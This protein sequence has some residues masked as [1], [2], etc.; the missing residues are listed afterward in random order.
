MFENGFVFIFV[1][2]FLFVIGIGIWAY[3]ANMKRMA[4]LRLWAAERRFRL[5]E[6]KNRGLELRFPEFACLREGSRR[7]GENVLEGT[8]R[9]RSF[10]AFEYHYETYSTDKD[11]KTQ[12]NHHSFAVV[13]VES[14]LRLKPLWIRRENFFDKIGSFIGFDDINF[15]SGEFSRRYHVSAQDRRWAFDVLHQHAIEFLLQAPD[16]LS[17]EM[18]ATGVMGRGVRPTPDEYE[19]SLNTIVGLLEMLP[20]SVIEELKD[21]R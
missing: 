5:S 3:R 17:L 15:E 1:L 19:A 14:P 13:V 9:E 10:T 2:F 20:R 18:Q 8:F 12:T 11:G 21:G 6:T 4:A 16:K 7:Y